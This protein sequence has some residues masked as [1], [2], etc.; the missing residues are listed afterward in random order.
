[1]P[2]AAPEPKAEIAADAVAEMAKI[3]DTVVEA[4]IAPAAVTEAD[5]A[6]KKKKKKKKK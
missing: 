6:D 2:T 5:D 1:M 3:R 4:S